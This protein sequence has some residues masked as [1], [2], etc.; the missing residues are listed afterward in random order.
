MRIRYSIGTTTLKHARDK[1]A[2]GEI[3]EVKYTVKISEDWMPRYMYGIEASWKKVCRKK[4]YLNYGFYFK[5][6]RVCRVVLVDMERII[7]IA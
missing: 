6:Q 5:C 3:L 7:D 1:I 2:P 4:P